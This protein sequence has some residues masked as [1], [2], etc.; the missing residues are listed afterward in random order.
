V[1]E[2]IATCIALAAGIAIE[3]GLGVFAIPRI[4]AAVDAGAARAAVRHRIRASWASPTR[5]AR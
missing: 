5:S 2:V 1:T 3:V 4:M